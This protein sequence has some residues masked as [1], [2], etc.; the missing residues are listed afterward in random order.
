MF[1]VLVCILAIIR[2]RFSNAIEGEIK[3]APD[4]ARELATFCDEGSEIYGNDCWCSKGYYSDNGLSPCNQCDYGSS[5]DVIGGKVTDC[6][7]QNGFYSS[8]GRA[9][10]DASAIF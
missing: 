8:D 1:V 9:P 2:F 4:V 10:C 6:I 7:C 5:S 3:T